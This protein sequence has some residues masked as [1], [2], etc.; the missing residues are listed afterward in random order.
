[1]INKTAQK[2]ILKL[3]EIAEKNGGY[4]VIENEPYMKLSVEVSE[5]YYS[6]GVHRLIL[7]HTNEQNGDLM[8][9]P[10]ITFMIEEGY[11]KPIDFTNDY[12]GCYKTVESNGFEKDIC[13]L[14]NL[15]MRN[16]KEQ[17]F[18]DRKK[19]GQSV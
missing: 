19:E 5:D 3:I 7:A 16:I 17:G 2:I 6:M 8:S 11:I 1:M 9:D 4:I 18:L 13:S 14:V 10:M 12:A 15:W